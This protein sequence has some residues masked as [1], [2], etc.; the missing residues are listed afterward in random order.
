V[1]AGDP[2]KVRLSKG[3]LEVQVT[4]KLEMKDHEEKMAKK[5]TVNTA[6]LTFEEAFAELEKIVN[7]LESNQSSLEESLSLFERGQALADHCAKLLEKA[8]IACAQ[9]FKPAG[10]GGA[11]LKWV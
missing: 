1:Q 7:E 4:R 10:G 8:E 11:E 6:N 9:S 2:A 3:G 5:E